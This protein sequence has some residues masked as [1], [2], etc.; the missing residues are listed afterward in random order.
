MFSVQGRPQSLHLAEKAHMDC[1]PP[2]PCAHFFHP[3]TAVGQTAQLLRSGD[4]W[5]QA[6]LLVEQEDGRTWR[7]NTESPN[8]SRSPCAQGKDPILLAVAPGPLTNTF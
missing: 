5:D 3:D 4:A 7:R 2:A 1:V 6:A 8:H